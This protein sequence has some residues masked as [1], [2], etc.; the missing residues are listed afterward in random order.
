MYVKY[1]TILIQPTLNLISISDKRQTSKQTNNRWIDRQTT[2]I[3][4]YDIFSISRF[5]L[6][7]ILF[8]RHDEEMDHQL[9][10]RVMASHLGKKKKLMNNL[11]IPNSNSYENIFESD[12]EQSS[13]SDKLRYH[14]GEEYQPIPPSLLKK[15]I[16]YARNKVSPKLSTEAAHIIQR[17]YIELRAFMNKCNSIPITTPHLESLIRLTEAR[18]RLD[19]R[20][21]A[22]EED[23]IDVIGIIKFNLVDIYSDEMGCVKTSRSTHSSGLSQH[24]QVKALIAELTRISE[25]R[26]CS[27]F[28]VDEMREVSDSI[29]IPVLRFEDIIYSLNNQCYLLKKGPLLYQLQTQRC[30]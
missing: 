30:L 4:E 12:T 22:T 29:G 28:S 17:F 7:F 19:L 16:A 5:D 15:Y 23:A 24:N 25:I 8:D 20:E 3:I 6:I 13:I 9:S 2:I 18:A 21:L 11:K 1:K 27:I 26:D 10:E 14:N